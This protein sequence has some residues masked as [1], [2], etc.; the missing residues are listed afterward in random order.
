MKVSFP[1][2]LCDF[3]RKCT[4]FAVTGTVDSFLRHFSELELHQEVSGL[5]LPKGNVIFILGLL[6]T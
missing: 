6:P 1:F 4:C 5:G 3:S 2:F